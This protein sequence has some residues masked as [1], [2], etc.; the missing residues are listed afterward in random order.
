M[1]IGHSGRTDGGTMMLD[2]CV[3][4][5]SFSCVLF[6]FTLTDAWDWSLFVQWDEPEA[7][8]NDPWKLFS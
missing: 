1:C 7:V 2:L 5:L 8:L 4:V 3:H 6:V